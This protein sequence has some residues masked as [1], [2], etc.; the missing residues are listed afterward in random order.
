MP[1]QPTGKVLFPD[2]GQ[3]HLI[4]PAS[5]GRTSALLTTPPRAWHHLFSS[6]KRNVSLIACFGRN[7]HRRVHAAV[8]ALYA[9][10]T[11]S[12]TSSQRA[13]ISSYEGN[14]CYPDPGSQVPSTHAQPT[15]PTQMHTL[16]R[17]GQQLPQSRLSRHASHSNEQASL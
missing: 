13:S 9:Q 17:G 16:L 10:S 2:L 7:I 15:P 12:Q 4:S 1:I 8:P 14:T 6:R 11:R 3:H 5:R